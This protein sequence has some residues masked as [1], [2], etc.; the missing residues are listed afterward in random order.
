VTVTSRGL[1]VAGVAVGAK[2]DVA[3]DDIVAGFQIDG[4]GVGLT[5]VEGVDPSDDLPV[6]ELVLLHR[7]EFVCRQ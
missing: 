6:L 5:W 2:L 4:Q 1:T 3:E 7:A